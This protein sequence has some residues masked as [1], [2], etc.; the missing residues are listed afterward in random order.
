MMR[1]YYDENCPKCRRW[2]SLLG[3]IALNKVVWLPLLAS[4]PWD[5]GIE[6]SRA[7]LEIPSL[8][9]QNKIAYG[10]DTL[11]SLVCVAPRLRVFWLGA[12]ALKISGLGSFFYKRLAAGR[13]RC[14]EEEGCRKA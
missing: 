12:Y 13:I 10:F 8:S 14:Q 4:K 6:Q 5:L 3:A 7:L 11:Y 9:P 1:I 2:A